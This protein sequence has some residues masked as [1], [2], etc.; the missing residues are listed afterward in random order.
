V[1]RRS[2]GKILVL[3]VL[4]SV[5][6]SCSPAAAPTPVPPK[7]ETAAAPQATA[8]SEPAGG[9]VEA[10]AQDIKAKLGGTELKIAAATH[11]SIEAFKKM[12]PRFEELT[13]IKV[14]W[15]EMEEGALGQKLAMEA[16][17]GTTGYDLIMNC[18]EYTPSLA[19]AG[20]LEPLD[21]FLGD[22]AKTPEWFDYKDILASYRDML[23]YQDKHYG[24]P[25]AGETVFL[26]YRKDLFE[27]YGA[28]VPATLDELKETAAFFNGKEPGL[29][30]VS[31]RTRLGWEA[32]YMWSVFIFPFGGRMVD[33]QTGKADLANPATAQSLQYMAD[34]VKL[35]PT[36]T[37]SYSF[38]EAWDAFM[39]GKTAMM[40]EANA[41]AP[42]VENPDKSVV[43]G[44]VGYAPMPAGPAG[45]FSGVWG[46]G[47]AMTKPSQKK[48]AGYAFLVYM[49]SKAMQQEYLAN[50]GIVSRESALGDPQ[51]Q[52]KYPYYQAT[53]DT[54]KEAADLQAKGLGVVLM[55]PEWSQ[56]SE[57]LGTEAA[58]AIVG[59][60]T[61]QQ[62]CESMQEQVADIL[63]Q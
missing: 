16:T 34:L 36:G 8:A 14:S 29:S 63:K 58:K 45:A 17:S 32:T 44:K 59:S 46:W 23:S 53:L 5:V 25:F 57:V 43:A 24:V 61:A 2:L 18:P 55:M 49:T 51:Q 39:Q 38:P 50:G 12:T 54:L 22:A 62:A 42:E 48:D 26:F 4:V 21:A 6:L 13:G 30:G 27:K 10:W 20:L 37:E 47:F 40:V 11:P 52:A 1:N 7:P 60:A 35:A 31:L 28:K 33:P 3:C 19:D 15:D 56:I 9:S 41:A